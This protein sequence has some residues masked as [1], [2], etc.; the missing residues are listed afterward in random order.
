MRL[1]L[2]IF[3]IATTGLANA[4]RW[5]LMG[6]FSL[7]DGEIGNKY[8]D[9]DSIQSD[10]DIATFWEWGRSPTLDRLSANSRIGYMQNQKRLDCRS[11]YEME[12][13]A[14]FVNPDNGQTVRLISRDSA[15]SEKTKRYHNPGTVGFDIA[16]KVC[17]AAN[18]LNRDEERRRVWLAKGVAERKAQSIQVL[19]SK[20]AAAFGNYRFHSAVVAS[21]TGNPYL[22]VLKYVRDSEGSSTIFGSAKEP[23]LVCRFR[24]GGVEVLY[25]EGA[26]LEIATVS[27]GVSL[28]EAPKVKV[29]NGKSSQ[30]GEVELERQSL[31][32]NVENRLES[33]AKLIVGHFLKNQADGYV[34]IAPRQPPQIDFLLDDDASLRFPVDKVS[35]SGFEVLWAWSRENCGVGVRN[36]LFGK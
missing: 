28:V 6:S 29:F 27:G 23:A 12:V 3:L 13:T 26:T 25:G 31:F 20:K 17:E 4:E 7:P 34:V 15:Y 19:L 35:L 2:W 10:G 21:P 1:V 33:K 16:K 36:N 14:R 9:F 32:D 8:I 11:M 18:Q 22:T 24:V 30:S 5:E